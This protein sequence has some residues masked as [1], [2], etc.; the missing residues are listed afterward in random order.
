M[1]TYKSVY[2]I[3]IYLYIYTY[4]YMYIYIYTPEQRLRYYILSLT[5]DKHMYIHF[6]INIYA[7]INTLIYH[8]VVDLDTNIHIHLNSVYGTYNQ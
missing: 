5:G 6:H 7:Y 2:Y 3:H 8:Y 1:Y 4:I